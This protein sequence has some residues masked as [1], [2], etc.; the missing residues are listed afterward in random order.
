MQNI[1][2]VHACIAGPDEADEHLTND[3]ELFHGRMGLERIGRYE[4]NCRNKH[5][6]GE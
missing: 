2:M 3:S 4:N 1:Y 6:I 5:N